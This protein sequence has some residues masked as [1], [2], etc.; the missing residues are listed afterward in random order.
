MSWLAKIIKLLELKKL[1]RIWKNPY[2]AKPLIIKDQ[3]R[4]KERKCIN[5][6]P[7]LIKRLNS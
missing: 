7:C 1:S 6:K 2:K 4:I 5:Y 3:F